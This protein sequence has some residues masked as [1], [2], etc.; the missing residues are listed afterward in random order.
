MGRCSS[1]IPKSQRLV[2]GDEAGV[3]AFDGAL[4][5]FATTPES[6][7]LVIPP[8]QLADMRVLLLLRLQSEK[9]ALAQQGGKGAAADARQEANSYH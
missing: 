8:Y 7:V 9:Q 2:T 1:Q 3:V 5:H 6:F 4:E